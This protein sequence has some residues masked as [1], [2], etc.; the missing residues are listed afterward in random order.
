MKYLRKI[1]YILFLIISMF[2]FA[3]YVIPKKITI[4]KTLDCFEEI[5]GKKVTVIISGIYYSYLLRDDCFN[6]TI[7]VENKR[8]CTMEYH[9]RKDLYT[10]FVDE[11]GQPEGMILQFKKFSYINIYD[12]DYYLYS[13]WDTAWTKEFKQK[14]NW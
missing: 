10:N 4:E 7:N 3:G 6:G 14:M 5:S 9:L 1:I 13:E 8:V 11:Y 2:I 12:L